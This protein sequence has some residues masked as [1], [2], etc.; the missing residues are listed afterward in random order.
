MYEA[1]QEEL[2]F[3]D[4]QETPNINTLNLTK[5]EIYQIKNEGFNKFM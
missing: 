1:I 5:E 3:Y 2:Q 4:L